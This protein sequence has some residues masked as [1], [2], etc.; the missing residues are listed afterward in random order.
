MGKRI[1]ALSLLLIPFLLAMSCQK[2][3]ESEIEDTVV[4]VTQLSSGTPATLVTGGADKITIMAT[5]G[6]SL[7]CEDWYTIEPASGTQG[8]SESTITVT[9]NTTGAPRTASIKLK[10]GSYNGTYTFTQAGQ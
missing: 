7:T 3:N 6:W 5:C 10:A 9:A 4:I 2:E 8:I 1:I